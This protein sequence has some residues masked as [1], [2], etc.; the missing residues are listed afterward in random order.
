MPILRSIQFS[1]A[2]SVT[3]DGTEIIWQVSIYAQS[4]CIWLPTTTTGRKSFSELKQ[5][6][7]SH[8]SK[9]PLIYG[10]VDCINRSVISK[11]A[12]KRVNKVKK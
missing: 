9:T 5:Y 2:T 11:N 3:L 7:V 12:N 8:N 6:Y 4:S 1:A 10:F